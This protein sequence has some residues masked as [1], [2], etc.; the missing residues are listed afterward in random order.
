MPASATWTSRSASRVTSSSRQPSRRRTTSR[1][2][3]SCLHPGG[4]R[5]RAGRRRRAHYNR[6][7]VGQHAGHR[8][9][10]G[11]VQGSEA[12]SCRDG[13]AQRPPGR[14][15]R[16][17]AGASKQPH[18]GPGPGLSRRS[19]GAATATSGAYRPRTAPM[20]PRA[21]P[22]AEPSRASRRRA[23]RG[24]GALCVGSLQMDSRTF[25]TSPDIVRRSSG[26]S[27]GHF[28][29]T[30]IDVSDLLGALSGKEAT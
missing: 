26:I 23:H 20:M 7:P 28:G 11:Q 13:R 10:A 2:V 18:P 4:L 25:R 22:S 15:D 30:S 12:N 16:S 27:A 24:L 19:T 8:T 1:K 9:D 6:H 29:H 14:L 3:R 17:R 21:R 5:A